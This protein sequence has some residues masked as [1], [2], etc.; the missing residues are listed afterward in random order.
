MNR[1]H[2]LKHIAGGMPHFGLTGEPE[3]YVSE[4]IVPCEMLM[5]LLARRNVGH[6]DVFII[7]TEGYDYHILKQIDLGRLR[8]KII[9]YEHAHLAKMRAKHVGCFHQ[10]ATGLS[11]AATLILW[12]SL[13]DGLGSAGGL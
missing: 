1:D 13:T 5:P 8:P 4:K 10:T 6:V 12:L 2:V 7:D 3:D 9:L 11:I